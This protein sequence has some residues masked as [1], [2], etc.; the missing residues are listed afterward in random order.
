[1]SFKVLFDANVLCQ[2]YPSEICFQF[3]SNELFLPL[4]SEKIFDEMREYGKSKIVQKPNLIL[5]INKRID[6]ISNIYKDSCVYGF[7]HL[8][9]TII[10]P[11]P[12]DA[13]ILAAAIQGKAA[14]IVTNN[15]KHFPNEILDEYGIDVYTPDEFFQLQHGLMPETVIVS[16]AEMLNRWDN[17]HTETEKFL[18]DIEEVFPLFAAILFENK[19]NIDFRRSML[20]K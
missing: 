20:D 13:H 4:W 2:L 8:E 6:I 14:V 9:P 19:G 10:L 16:I 3:A 15:V 12:G 7:E 1:M 17:P 11:D 18:K 5:G